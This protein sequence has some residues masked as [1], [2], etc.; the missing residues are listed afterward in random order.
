MGIINMLQEGGFST[1]LIAITMA[2]SIAFILER[3]TKL[4]SKLNIN[5]NSFMFEVQKQFMSA[6]CVGSVALCAVLCVAVLF[7]DDCAYLDAQRR[8]LEEVEEH[9]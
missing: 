4:Y 8:V 6:G 3:F 5:G 9:Y 1:Y 7:C 2:A